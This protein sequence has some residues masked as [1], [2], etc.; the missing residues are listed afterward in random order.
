M[1]TYDRLRIQAQITALRAYRSA[2]HEAHESLPDDEYWQTNDAHEAEMAQ[3]AA[4]M[5]E[6]KTQLAADAPAR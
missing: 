4:Q 1:T 2:L 6:L 5:R 3:T